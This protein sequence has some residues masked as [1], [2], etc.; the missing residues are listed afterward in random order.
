MARRRAE[1]RAAAR[2]RFGAALAVAALLLAGT[3]T[4]VGHD[5][6][7]DG[8]VVMRIDAGSTAGVSSSTGKWGRDRFF[9]GGYRWGGRWAR[10]SGTTDDA[11]YGTM[12]VGVRGYDILLSR[13]GLYRVQLL[14]AETVYPVQ[15]RRVFDVTA[16]GK[17]VLDDLDVLSRAGF[18]VAHLETVVVNVADTVLNLG[19][20]PG[21]GEPMV[22]AIEV[23][24]EPPATT[25][26]V[27]PTT[28]PAPTTTPS[29]GPVTAAPVRAAPAAEAQSATPATADHEVA[30]AAGAPEVGVGGCAGFPDGACTGWRHTGASLSPYTGPM[31]ITAAGSVI[32][33]KV[34]SGAL[35]V[36]AADVIIRRS[37][38][39]GTIDVGYG[40]SRNVLIEDVEID[41]RNTTYA[42]LGAAN[43]T[44]RRCNIHSAGQGVNGFNFVLEDSWIHDLYGTGTVHS[45]AVLGYNG[46]I[47]L[48]GNRLSGN[49]NGASG[50]FASG[51]GG[52]S[53][54]VALYTHGSWGP[55]NNVVVE[56]NRL[57]VG[58]GDRDYAGFCLYGG[59][60]L[61]SN[62]VF[63]GNVFAQNPM[64]PSRCG[65]HG[66]VV[67]RPSGPG[68][69]WEDNRMEDGTPT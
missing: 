34:I 64:N 19:F 63:R 6:A 69:R 41:G 17:V 24:E 30:P 3:V 26:T 23:L 67:D 7:G 60:T 50:G 15:Q 11:L 49:Y 27:P 28:A 4:A 29:S 47:V 13:P 56:H 2:R 52:M 43:F 58:S 42:G 16:E 65:Y 45:E 25:T 46:N 66:S 61:M 20:T 57:N 14:F 37:H 8:G 10:V 40:E 33:D 5:R 39:N 62:G 53:A 9:T 38:V 51:D 12:R 1:R 55:M 59:G 36:R 68:S 32:E 44:C 31:T 18:R 48:R 54:A 35:V 22:S 21:V